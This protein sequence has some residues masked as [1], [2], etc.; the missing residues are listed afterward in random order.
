MPISTLYILSTRHR[1]NRQPIGDRPPNGA[2]HERS[3][4]RSLLPNTEFPKQ[5]GARSIAD[6]H[7]EDEEDGCQLRGVPAVGQGYRRQPLGE[8]A[9]E[10]APV[11]AR[12]APGVEAEPHGQAL[13]GEVF[14]VA[15]VPSVDAAGGKITGGQ[16]PTA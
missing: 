2:D 7:A 3:P 1:R 15:A 6:R 13:P 9:A 4:A 11:F 5:T 16:E 12:P 14:K 10:T 8:G